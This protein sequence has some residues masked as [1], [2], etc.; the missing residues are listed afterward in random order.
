LCLFYPDAREWYW[1]RDESFLDFLKTPVN[2]HFLSQI[3]FRQ[4]GKW[5]FGEMRHGVYGCFD[6]YAEKLGTANINVIISALECL[7]SG[8]APKGHWACY[9]GSGKRMRNCHIDIL[10]ILHKKIKPGQISFSLSW[11]RRNRLFL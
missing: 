1:S 3:Y 2:D 4:Y 11:L 7:E 6:F 9:C 10:R 5:P 8:K